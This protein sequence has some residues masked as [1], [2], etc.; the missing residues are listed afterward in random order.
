MADVEDGE[1]LEGRSGKRGSDR[2]ERGSKKEG[3]EAHGDYSS[4]RRR[5]RR[6]SR[7]RER[8]RSHSRDGYRDR[9][10]PSDRLDRR[11]YRRDRD[12]RER[13]TRDHDRHREFPRELDAGRRKNQRYRSDRDRVQVEDQ[14]SRSRKRAV[15]D[16]ENRA[17]EEKKARSDQPLDSPLGEEEAVQGEAIKRSDDE[18]VLPSSEEELDNPAEEIDL[19]DEETA[20][21]KL[22]RERKERRERL[23]DK[24]KREKEDKNE[25]TAIGHS[26][27]NPLELNPVEEPSVVDKNTIVVPLSTQDADRDDSIHSS[28]EDSA[29]PRKYAER[30][31][32]PAEQTS[33]QHAG[34]SADEKT[35]IRDSLLRMRE[36]AQD[37]EVLPT[38]NRRKDESN[39]SAHM[40][41]MF[42]DS[43]VDELGESALPT[44]KLVNAAAGNVDATDTEGY[45]VFRPG[46]L[47]E[48][49]YRVMNTMGKGVFS[50]VIRAQD[51]RSQQD[52]A[53]KAIRNNDVMLRA[54]QKEIA[55][56]K[57]LNETD[58]QGKRHCVKF[59]ESF[60]HKGH[61]CLVFECLDVNLR[62]LL[63]KYGSGRG[64][65]M[66]GVR[67]YASQMLSAL[68]L[69]QKNKVIH[70][71]IKPDNI[72]VTKTKNAIKL[73][74][75][76]SAFTT[77]EGMELTPYLVS[78]FYRAPEIVLGLPY[79][80]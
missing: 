64:I 12:D 25:N 14:G 69:L 59:L 47:L 53:V 34:A 45:Y 17:R 8:R 41:D 39:T 3:R 23:L 16:R 22:I 24:L 28:A 10:R 19:F 60:Q 54:G 35:R 65:S 42:S 13:R 21:E 56:L 1:L 62:E 11:D 2:D 29:M 7:S 26:Q 6:R 51:V 49:R 32:Q 5:D 72:M 36:M 48:G 44:S 31:S 63:R 33:S 73:G 78:R 38:D 46:E 20:E 58:P 52:F 15:E 18:K 27:P 37:E 9:R 76:G 80:N 40:F 74:D 79:G 67:I 30:K 71:D 75:F 70:A 57:K 43:P 66:Q 4:S 77:D 68:Y 61:L 55:I 50:T